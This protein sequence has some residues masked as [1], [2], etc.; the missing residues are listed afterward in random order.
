MAMLKEKKYL[1]RG[2]RYDG[3]WV[4]GYF[5]KM[6]YHTS[7]PILYSYIS[8]P[9]PDEQ[10]RPSDH[11]MVIP[12]TVTEYIGIYDK[13]SK[14]IFRGDICKFRYC[15]GN[16]EVGYVDYLSQTRRNY[17]LQYEIMQKKK[18]GTIS[19]DFEFMD[20]GEIEVIGNIW[21]NPELLDVQ[22]DK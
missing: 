9:H 14:P 8:V 22:D 20:K 7:K 13:N 15:G 3:V 1:F 18:D 11:Y 6:K 10:G 5:S 19:C 4:E 17:W 16:V 21:D 12:D 2:K